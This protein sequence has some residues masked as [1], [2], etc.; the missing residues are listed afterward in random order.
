M[1]ENIA[2]VIEMAETKMRPIP[3]TAPFY[4][5]VRIETSPK[6]LCGLIPRRGW[7]RTLGTKERPHAASEP[8]PECQKEAARIYDW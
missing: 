6:A 4:H 1:S 7:E 2:T 5:L 3:E 8:C